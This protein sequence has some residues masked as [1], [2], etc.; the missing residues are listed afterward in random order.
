MTAVLIVRGRAYVLHSGGTAAYLAHRG[1]VVALSGDDTFDEAP[2]TLLS[3]ALG[4]TPSLDVAVTSV[5]LDE[6]DVIVLVGRRV[7]GEIDRRA[8]ISHVETA[9]P[10]EHVLVARFERDDALER[11]DDDD[12][13]A[14]GGRWRTATAWIGP[15]A[16]LIAAIGVVLAMV[17]A[18]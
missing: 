10:S 14:T 11:A 16:R 18:R 1:D 5:T 17:F 7:R 9:D 8:L 3:R 15:V 4:T 6:G 2:T 12:S 13:G